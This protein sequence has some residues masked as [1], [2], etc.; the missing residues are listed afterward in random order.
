MQVVAMVATSLKRMQ[1]K[2]EE[3]RRGPDGLAQAKRGGAYLDSHKKPF[4]FHSQS[5]GDTPALEQPKRMS[6]AGS[7]G[8]IILAILEIQVVRKLER[9]VETGLRD[10]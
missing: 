4:S 3:R 9:T 8:S 5:C 6:L 10:L 2:E 7:I 1:R